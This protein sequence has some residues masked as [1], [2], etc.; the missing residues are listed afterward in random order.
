RRT[1]QWID[2]S[3]ELRPRIDIAQ[4]RQ[5]FRLHWSKSSNNS[6]HDLAVQ[7]VANQILWQS[8]AAIHLVA[9]GRC[10]VDERTI[11]QSRARYSCL[12]VSNQNRRTPDDVEIRLELIGRREIS[13]VN[14]KLKISRDAAGAAL[15]PHLPIV[16]LGNPPL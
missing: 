10:R 3:N 8:I 2:R 15:E 7:V 9:S 14:R 6:S 12:D 5:S 4:L 13:I 11:R 16:V 1:K